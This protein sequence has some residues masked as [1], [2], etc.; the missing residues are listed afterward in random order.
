MVRGQK[1]GAIDDL[2]RSAFRD[3]RAPPQ[4]PDS[5]D[6]QKSAKFH[7]L[8]ALACLPW[9]APENDSAGLFVYVHGALYSILFHISC[10]TLL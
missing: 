6:Q 1:L 7:W 10:S 5:V 4:I 2:P 8:A 3:S 9:P